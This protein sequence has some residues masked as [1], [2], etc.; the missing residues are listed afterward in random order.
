MIETYACPVCSELFRADVEPN[1]SAKVECPSCGGLVEV[2]GSVLSQAPQSHSLLL[3]QLDQPLQPPPVNPHLVPRP[4]VYRPNPFETPQQK[5]ARAERFGL[6]P[7]EGRMDIT[8]MP[9]SGLLSS[10]IGNLIWFLC[11]GL[12]MGV[13]Y[14]VSAMLSMATIIGI[15]SGLQGI[16]IGFYAMWPFGSYIEDRGA[17][18][19]GTV[20]NL[21][22]FLLGGWALM[23][24]HLLWALI[25]TILI[26]TYPFAVMHFRLASLCAAPYGKVVKSR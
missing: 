11:G 14:L 17:G 7:K 13:V 10:L 21:I 22:W 26:V 16:K 23:L 25:F 9:R 1:C 12:G 5:Q 4:V 20:G 24:G 3:P 6:V 18:C 2:S 15:P 8:D 19:L